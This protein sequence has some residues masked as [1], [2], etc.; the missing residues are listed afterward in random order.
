M[1]AY[2]NIK[3]YLLLLKKTKDPELKNK[4]VIFVNS[5]YLIKESL[6]GRMNSN[7]IESKDKKEYLEY[8]EIFHN[9]GEKAAIKYLGN[10][11]YLLRL[12]RKRQNLEVSENF[13]KDIVWKHELPVFYLNST[14]IAKEKIS[15][16]ASYLTEK[17]NPRLDSLLNTILR[18]QENRKTVIPPPI[19]PPPEP[20]IPSIHS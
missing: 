11:S 20:D 2:E 17:V 8:I 5:C 7:Q 10:E 6:H 15:R 12:L 16:M 13:S 1:K 19:S 14:D 3:H 9:E 18:S 4:V